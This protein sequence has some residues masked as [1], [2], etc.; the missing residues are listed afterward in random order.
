MVMKQL[1]NKF[2]P[3]DMVSLIDMNQLKQ[4]ISLQTPDSNPQSLF[5][6]MPAWKINS[7]REWMIVR[8]SP[9]LLRIASQIP[10][11]ADH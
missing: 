9:L 4:R 1:F 5:E 2:K 3:Q 6:W 7:R 10:T 11:C 8:R